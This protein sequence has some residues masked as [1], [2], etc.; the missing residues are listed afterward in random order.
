MSYYFSFL[1]PILLLM[2]IIQGLPRRFGRSSEGPRTTIISA[3][4]AV[5]ISLVPVGGI[6]LARYLIS[7]N[8][9]FSIPL[10]AVVPAIIWRR[11]GGAEWLD[12]RT[13]NGF[14]LYGIVS[15]LLLYPMALGLGPF[16][17]YT[18]GWGFSP[19]FV[20]FLLLTVFLLYKKHPLGVVLLLGILAYN[21][22]VL[23]SA[24]LW[25]YMIDPVFT[26]TSIIAWAK[27]K[28]A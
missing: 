25:D 16:D 27:R 17:P 21:L 15:G 14:W 13:L 23:E 19:L 10:T 3:M 20:L 11:A 12:R 28:K 18:L 4:L 22:Q 8:A 2:L 7:V 26:I 24:N 5:T 1:F 9:N 6:P